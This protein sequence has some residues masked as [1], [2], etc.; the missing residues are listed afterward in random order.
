MI[1][2]F[3]EPLGPDEEPEIIL[4]YNHSPR[5]SRK[6]GA[7]E[8]DTPK[9]QKKVRI[10]EEVSVKETENYIQD[11]DKEEDTK[12]VIDNNETPIEQIVEA[13]AEV[14]Q[15]TEESEP[16]RSTEAEA[17]TEDTPKSILKRSQNLLNNLKPHS[18]KFNSGTLRKK[19]NTPINK[20][21]KMAD[22]QF[23]K[24]KPTKKAIKKIPI[25]KNDIILED[26]TK[27]LKLKESPKS[28]NRELTSYVVKQD[29]DDTVEIMDLDESP[30]ETRKRRDEEKDAD[31]TIVVPD[32]IIEIPIT[33]QIETDSQGS[34]EPT[35]D[36]ILKEELKNDPPPKS[37]RKKR[38]HVYEDIEK[39]LPKEEDHAEHKL[40]RQ[41]PIDT[42]DPIFQD[43]V[44]GNRG[45]KISLQIQ[46]EKITGDM[47]FHDP[48]ELIKQVSDEDREDISEKS[49][50]KSSLSAKQ[51][52]LAPISS[53]DSTSSDEGIKHQLSIVA[54]ESD[55]SQS[56]GK[57]K[58]PD[59]SSADEDVASL[60]DEGSV[61]SGTLIEE[62]LKG[63]IQEKFDLSRFKT[64]SSESKASK[65]ES[66]EPTGE[67]MEVEVVQPENIETNP[68]ADNIATSN[69]ALAK[70]HESQET[71]KSHEESPANATVTEIPSDEEEGVKEDV[72]V[73]Q[74]TPKAEGRISSRW[75][76]MR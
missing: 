43:F 24:V 20:I 66:K 67:H 71:L 34:Q 15:A 18:S 48:P 62:E 13:V 55:A 14:P 51:Q 73:K 23:K 42:F 22:K 76:K 39:S 54:E 35:V 52:L 33:T 30:S 69:E 10:Q 56:S 49:A 2:I 50:P 58:L 1:R 37:P 41:T 8:T 4:K 5:S 17:V 25:S 16:P 57:K 64:S 3:L 46:D 11:L 75:S 72:E 40:Q 12:K 7:E 61:I 31:T 70:S 65:E 6:F 60:D 28:R 21:R 32:E 47:D 38:D 36:E 29:S 45:M 68:K 63:G 19:L 44:L 26:E 59:D 9:S 27:I 74:E 53:I